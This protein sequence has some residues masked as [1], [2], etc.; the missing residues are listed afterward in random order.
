MEWCPPETHGSGGKRTAGVH[1]LVP[2]PSRA[3]R[4][5]KRCVG[6]QGFDFLGDPPIQKGCGPIFRGSFATVFI[7]LWPG[8]KE[9]FPISSA[10][11]SGANVQKARKFMTAKM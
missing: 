10:L 6:S 7:T 3:T 11:F 4:F 1:R 5:A 9:I 8:A 2:S